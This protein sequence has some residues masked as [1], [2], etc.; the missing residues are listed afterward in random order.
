MERRSVSWIASLL[1]LYFPFISLFI[2]LFF[3]L[4]KLFF[5]VFVLSYG[6]LIYLWKKKSLPEADLFSEKTAILF[7]D[8]CDRDM[9]LFR[10]NSISLIGPINLSLSLFFCLALRCACFCGKQIFA[11]FFFAFFGKKQG[12]KI[13]LREF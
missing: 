12:K 5:L 9:A 2:R 10:G 3:S 7:L 8:S 4:K 1:Q 13:L 11:R 6:N